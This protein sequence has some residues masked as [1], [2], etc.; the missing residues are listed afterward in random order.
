MDFHEGI[1]LCSL[2]LIYIISVCIILCVSHVPASRILCPLVLQST[3][4]YYTIVFSFAQRN[5]STPIDLSPYACQRVSISHA[6]VST[7]T[8]LDNLDQL[9]FSPAAQ[10]CVPGG[11]GQ[12]LL[13]LSP[14]FYRYVSGTYWW[15]VIFYTLLVFYLVACTLLIVHVY[16]YNILKG[17][18]CMVIYVYMH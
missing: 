16:I 11:K 3:K 2:T 13:Y 4:Y 8:P 10:I 14:I 18:V 7:L 15:S 6:V 17:C 1:K 9:S 5:L 12:G